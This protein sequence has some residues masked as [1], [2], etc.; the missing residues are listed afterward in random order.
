VT[1]SEQLNRIVQLVAEL[2]RREREAQ[3]PATLSELAARFGTT[4]AQIQSDIRTL[5]L[6]GDDPDADWLLSL[7][8]SQE[9]ETVRLW[10]S[11][12]FRR[13]LR[14]TPDELLA[15]KVGLATE[16]DGASL[17]ANPVLQGDERSER[18]RLE[19]SATP[20]LDL[21]VKAA[22]GNRCVETLYA[23]EG[24]RTGSERVIQPHQVVAFAGRTYV[25]AWCEAV[26]GWRHF[27]LD[28]V[29]D[30]L[31][32]DRTFTR[33]DDFEPV[34][35]PEHIF[36]EPDEGVD[37]VRVSFSA[38]VARWILEPYPDAEP[39][40]DGGAVVTYRVAD[41]DWLVRRVLQYGPEAQVLEPEAYRE[42]MR[43]AV[44]G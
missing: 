3:P 2:T 24:A 25:A 37:D 21:F 23:G 38:A 41:V 26:E 22:D 44:A 14:L 7:G 40:P 4:V 10:S 39:Q 12:P 8:V 32:I 15:L 11:G 42:A 36:R 1:A 29:I 13:P 43:R 35:G 28:R 6:L 27:R 16:P 30:A 20:F 5:T 18:V 31:P 33:R 17:A 9:G 34:D 19:S